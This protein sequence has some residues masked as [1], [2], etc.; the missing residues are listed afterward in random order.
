M[1][2]F[3]KI[4]PYEMFGGYLFRFATITGTSQAKIVYRARHD[5]SFFQE[6]L[7][8]NHLTKKD[9]FRRHAIIIYKPSL[10]NEYFASRFVLFPIL[11][12][13][14]FYKFCKKCMENDFSE[15]GYTY[16]RSHLQPSCVFSCPQHNELLSKNSG[17]KFSDSE[18]ENIEQVESMQDICTI[19]KL[20]SNI[21][22]NGN[23]NFDRTNL[24][25]LLIKKA[26]TVGK[27]VE[28]I[29]SKLSSSS[30]N[31]AKK[32]IY[33]NHIPYTR[34]SYDFDRLLF[35]N[36]V[37]DCELLFYSAIL[38]TNTET[39]KFFEISSNTNQC[40]LR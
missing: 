5:N 20:I 4:L 26:P 29:K 36:G 13:H 1:N 2:T 34:K 10:Q 17:R 21:I 16:Y 30:I 18:L 12:S 25:K 14:K 40:L 28:C 8:R 11:S 32:Y 37:T 22:I 35:T 39:R 15:L 6:L 31:I 9:L 7:D 23:M 24:K 33:K 19:L 27:L 38:F 3:P